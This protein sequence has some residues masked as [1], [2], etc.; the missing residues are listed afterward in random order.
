[1]G[2]RTEDLRLSV[3]LQSAL[4]LVSLQR[5]YAT[6]LPMVKTLGSSPSSRVFAISRMGS[7]LRIVAAFKS[8]FQD[9]RSFKAANSPVSLQQGI[10]HSSSFRCRLPCSLL[11]MTFR[12]APLEQK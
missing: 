3:E 1:M 8:V 2:C 6:A 10:I 12:L 9:F 5:K 11:S 4:S 7:W